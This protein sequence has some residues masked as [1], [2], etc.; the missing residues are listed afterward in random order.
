MSLADVLQSAPLRLLGTN[1]VATLH[2]HFLGPP[3]IERDGATVD[4]DTRKAVAALAY[5]A[6]VSADGVNARD[7]LVALL[8]PDYS[9][10]RAR[11][12]FRRT[13]SSLRIGI[14]ADLLHADRETVSLAREGAVWCDVL[15]FRELR[16]QCKRH[17]HGA[18]EICD[19]CLP[20]L[21]EAATHYRGDF[22]AGFGLRDSVAFDDWQLLEAESLRREFGSVL[23][24][25][26]RGYGAL[27]RWQQAIDQC[28]RWI[29]LDPMHEP[30]HRRLMQ[31]YA[32]NGQRSA[33]LRQYRDCVRILDEELSVPPLPE[34]TALYQAIIEGAENTPPEIG[35]DWRVLTGDI[36]PAPPAPT[37]QIAAPAARF[38]SGRFALVGREKP[39]AVLSS[40]YAR[41]T[42]GQLVVIEGEAGIG[43][44]RLAEEFVQ[45]ATCQGAATV[46]ARCYEGDARLAYGPIVD[47]LRAALTAPEQADRLAALPAIWLSELRRLTPEVAALHPGLLPATD[48]DGPGAQ[49]RFFEAIAQA[50]LAA[51]AGTVP[52]VLLLDDVQWADEATLDVLAF[53][54]RRLRGQPLLLLT[55]LRSEQS[56][57]A[58]KMQRL[59]AECGRSGHGAAL[60]LEL[61]GPDD[62]GQLMAQ[63]DLGDLPEGSTERLYQETEGLPLFVVEYLAGVNSGELAATGETWELP[64][65][66]RQVLQAR[67]NAVNDV[68]RQLLTAAAVIGRSFAFDTLRSVSGRSEE[69]T[70]GGLEAVAAVGLIRELRANDQAAA[71]PRYDF[72]HEQLR[73]VIYEEISLAR[74]RLLHRRAAEA[75]IHGAGQSLGAAASQIAHHLRLAGS[76]GEAAGYYKLAGAH[77]RSVFANN[78]ALSHLAAALALAP[79][80]PDA[81]EL[82]EAMGDLLTLQG[83]YTPAVM[84]FETAAAV[85]GVERLAHLEHKMGLVHM[86]QGQ[87]ELADARFAAASEEAGGQDAAAL[88]ADWSLCAHRQGDSLR[89]GELAQQAL[90]VAEGTGD[91]RSLARAT[92]VLGV[93]A[94]SEN[95]LIGANSY[96]QTSLAAAQRLDDLPA[97]VA[98]LNNLALT[99]HDRADNAQARQYLEDALALCTKVGDQHRQAALH[100]NLA[101]LLHQTGQQDEAMEHLKQAVTIFATIGGQPAQPAAWQPEIWKLVEW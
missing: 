89:A 2:L 43:K 85:N 15:R 8:Y 9:Q 46:A 71:E 38:T 81:G 26:V 61:L 82:H 78:E 31:I 95:D 58:D 63:A 30:G 23:E 4:L 24:R 93:L 62:V 27:G 47:A 70:V 97:Q 92:N 91:D 74:R 100:N 64:R 56:A 32:W 86:R 90:R 50:F 25:L 73:R 65:G 7:A 96:L 10:E 40:I 21:E 60:L 51:L 3:R 17:G 5:L 88:Y 22:L 77:A 54:T 55:T 66:V 33:A 84:A 20:L 98:A 18:S 39:L 79:G 42:T 12:A 16:D 49:A 72:A 19:D 1:S 52:G 94:R 67:V 37:Q 28:H 87:W 29:S 80:A 69:E 13:L 99:A 75:L 44:T 59:L 83:A 14:G 45:Q 35:D 68:G 76:D 57:A 41:A 11:A 6:V 53:L 34:T 101:D 48:L 36:R